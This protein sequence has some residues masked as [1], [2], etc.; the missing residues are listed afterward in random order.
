MA[1]RKR[2]YIGIIGGGHPAI[3][4]IFHM[5]VKPTEKNTNGRYH[6]CIGPFRTDTGA[7]V[8]LDAGP[9]NPSIVTVNDAERIAKQR[10]AGS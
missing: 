5:S 2:P 4:E 1:T 6:A 8:M 9:N 10:H 3:R 7:R